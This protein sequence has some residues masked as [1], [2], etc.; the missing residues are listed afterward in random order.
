M[1]NEPKSDSEV[2]MNVTRGFLARG[3]CASAALVAARIPRSLALLVVVWV[4]I[5]F[6]LLHPVGSRAH[7]ADYSVTSSSYYIYNSVLKVGSNGTLL[8]RSS[9]L[10]SN[11]S[12]S[13]IAGHYSAATGFSRVSV[14]SGGADCGYSDGCIMFD[15][16]QTSNDWWPSCTTP[17]VYQPTNWA[18]IYVGSGSYNN[19]NCY[20][21][22][23]DYAP[24]WVVAIH[25]GNVPNNWYAYQHVGR[26]EVGHALALGEAGHSCWS[27]SGVYYPLMNNGPAASACGPAQ[28][29]YLTPNEVSAII[30]R[31]GWY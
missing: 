5:G 31:N 30:S 21:L 18:T 17:D 27:S 25:I 26:H 10:S 9:A 11:L 4:A 7:D 12:L 20:G 13:D 29:A 23:S 14:P 24:V 16:R 15:I 1:L 8:L 28:N 2:C 22:G 3:A 19:T 6:V